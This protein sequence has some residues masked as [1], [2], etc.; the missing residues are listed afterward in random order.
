MVYEKCEAKRLDAQM[1]IRLSTLTRCLGTRE[2]SLRAAR[3]VAD[4]PG[5]AAPDA[6]QTGMSLPASAAR[7][8]GSIKRC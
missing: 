4:E 6:R 5:T 1:T 2:R 8:V 3:N 7:E